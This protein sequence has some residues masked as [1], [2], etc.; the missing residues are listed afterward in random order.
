MAVALTIELR[1]TK[2]SLLKKLLITL[3]LVPLFVVHC[4]SQEKDSLANSALLDFGSKKLVDI[5][6]LLKQEAE[7]LINEG[8][9][10]GN[11]LLV[12]TGNE[13]QGF[14][15]EIGFLLKNQ[16]NTLY[17][18]LGDNEQLLIAQVFQL[19]NEATQDRAFLRDFSDSLT[20]D[21]D[22]LISKVKFFTRDR[23][24][25]LSLRGMAQLEKSGGDYHLA[26][27]ANHVAPYIEGRL[28]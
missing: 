4:Q 3:P 26:L 21:L 15:L 1:R 12:T 18:D 28:K 10:A 27:T 5:L 8:K 24:N 6:S 22:R 19:R 2:R 23:F 14:A 16:E 25:V 20:V 9:R 7:D 13:M 17:K 11:S